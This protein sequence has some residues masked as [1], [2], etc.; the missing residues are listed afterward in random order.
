MIKRHLENEIQLLKDEYPVIA[1]VGP[2]QSGKTTL[3]K[4]VFSEYEYVSL[5][6]P[7]IRA[8]AQEDPRGFFSRYSKEVIFDEIQRVPDL[9][10]Y[11]QTLVDAQVGNAQFVITGSHNFL[12]REAVSQSLA[13][14][15]GITTLLPFS[16]TELVYSDKTILEWMF[17]GFFPRIH[18]QKIRPDRFYKNYIATYIEKDI[19]QIRQV[20]KL[21]VFARFMKL[22]A[23]RV[24]QELNLSSLG[25]EC[26]VSHNTMSDWLS[27]LETCFIIYRM[28][29]YHR[30]YNK[31][32][33]KRSK[34]YFTDT[35][36]VCSLLGLKKAEE[37]DFHFLKGS[38][39][40]NLVVSELLK[41]R[42]NY[43]E[44]FEMYF[45]RENHGKEIDVILDYGVRQLAFEIKSGQTLNNRF[46]SGLKYWHRLTGLTEKD[47]YLVYG[48]NEKTTRNGYQVI[49]WYRFAE[50]M[51]E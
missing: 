6:D 18:D 24:G 43:G 33:V 28:K 31:R 40:E 44:P 41:Y 1:I 7:D 26:G 10:N 17:T 23:G 51:T 15:V 45:W 4:K 30:N 49:P 11:M 36:L 29:P 27:L 3:A 37:L 13:G 22:L 9:L 46:F 42:F 48:G 16:V 20:A 47:L 2:R 34:L 19:R 32:L 21:D 35:G 14:R 50:S 8:F 25:D 39:F 12:L 5:E 38:L